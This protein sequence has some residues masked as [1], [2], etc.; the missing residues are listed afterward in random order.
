LTGLEQLRGTYIPKR[1]EDVEVLLEKYL[2]DIRRPDGTYYDRNTHIPKRVEVPVF[3]NKGDE[4]AWVAEQIRRCKEGY[5]G[6]APAM[7]FYYNFCYILTPQGKKIRPLFYRTQND[8]FWEAHHRLRGDKKGRGIILLKRRRWGFSWGVEALILAEAIFYKNAW[9]GQQSKGEIDVHALFDKLKYMFDNLP[10]Q[11]K[12]HT[13]NFSLKKI[14]FAKIT[15]RGHNRKV[16]GNNSTVECRLS[17]DVAWEGSGMKIWYSD[18]SGKIPNIGRNFQLTEPALLG[19]DGFSRAGL[20]IIGGTAGDVDKDAWEFVELWK[21]AAGHDLDRV[22]IPGWANMDVD[23][24]MNEDVETAVRKILTKRLKLINSPKKLYMTI[25]QF[26]LTPEEALLGGE[27]P[28]FDIKAINAQMNRLLNDPANIQRGYFQWVVEGESVR[29]VPDSEGQVQILEHPKDDADYAGGTDPVDHY[30]GEGSHQSTV[31]AKMTRTASQQEIEGMLNRL[32]LDEASTGELV[33]LALKTGEIPV[34]Y[35]RDNPS[36][37][38][39]AW[40]QGLMAAI[41]YSKRSYCQLHIERNRVGMINWMRESGMTVYM[42]FKTVDSR[43]MH[44][45]QQYD[46]GEHI[47]GD[48]KLLRTSMIDQYIR[49]SSW[50]IFFYDWLEHAKGYDPDQQRKKYDDI[51]AF[52]MWLL[53]VKSKGFKTKP[54][55]ETAARKVKKRRYVKR[56][57]KI[58]LEG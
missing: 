2:N 38:S 51:D 21:E 4:R 20:A 7:Y 33:E 43:K 39:A 30:G 27:S 37:P 22:F 12:P 6:M 28:C 15:G 45:R 32:D 9:I 55:K 47:D 13:E 14:Y 44:A 3:K 16:Q 48:K 40:E 8:F 18:E 35:Y 46:Y 56:N 58:V 49:H 5:D 1:D 36:D 23:E 25:Q 42:H 11:L 26:P 19:E 53:K 41:Y 31:I 24:N 17:T 54:K 52:G 57:G 10:L 34:L 50:K 29:F